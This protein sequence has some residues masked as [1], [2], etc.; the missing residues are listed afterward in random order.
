MHKD[1]EELHGHRRDHSPYDHVMPDGEMFLQYAVPWVNS[2]GIEQRTE[3]TSELKLD[4]D[5]NQNIHQDQ[6]INRERD[7]YRNRER[8]QDRSDN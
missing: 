3:S 7:E 1:K 6:D 8:S 5:L 2:N 4:Q